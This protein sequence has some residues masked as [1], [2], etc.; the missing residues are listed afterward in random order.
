MP[1]KTVRIA[2]TAAGNRYLVTQLDFNANV[3][4]CW[5][6]VVGGSVYLDR[7]SGAL[8]AA[9]SKH[10]GVQK[11]PLASVK[12][13]TVPSTAELYHSLNAQAARNRQVSK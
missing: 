4:L 9:R 11:F 6:E 7:D 5:G 10:S 2:T 12:I 1:T 13:E 3:S 8:T